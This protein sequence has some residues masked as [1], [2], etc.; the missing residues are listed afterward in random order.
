[1]NN[2]GVHKT[3]VI[4][5]IL[6]EGGSITLFGRKKIDGLWEFRRSVN[7]QTPTFLDDEDGGSEI[8][9][10]T[11]AVDSWEKAVVLLDKYPWAFLA[12]REVHPEFRDRVWNE[13]SKRL[14]GRRETQAAHALERWAKVCG[15]DFERP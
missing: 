14:K 6:A 1:M 9:H 8:K 4:V 2:S 10:G 12:G 3:S 7:D 13:V 11:P 5:S 15:A